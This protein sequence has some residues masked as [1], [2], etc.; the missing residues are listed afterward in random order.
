MRLN[1][2]IF[3]KIN[4]NRNQ[5]KFYLVNQLIQNN[6]DFCGQRKNRKQVSNLI[7]EI[8]L[9]LFTIR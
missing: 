8:K 3:T 7:S 6:I 9:Q 4:E 5:F 1:A 2:N